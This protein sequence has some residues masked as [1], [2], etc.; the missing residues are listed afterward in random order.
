MLDQQEKL[1]DFDA[2]ERGQVGNETIVEITAENI[3]EYARVAL[4]S[5]PRYQPSAS[6][7]LAMPTMVLSYAPLLRE[8]IAEANGF[9]AYEVSKTARRQTPF[10][11]CEARWFHPVVPGDTITGRRRVLEKYE[12]RGS[13]FVTFRVEAINQRGEKAAEYDYTC[14]FEYAKGQREAPANRDNPR[15]DAEPETPQA[16]R[17]KL[18]DYAAA[19]IGDTLAGLAITESQEIIN[20]RSDFRLAG[21]PNESN[22]HTDEEFAKQNIFGGTVNSG[23]ATMSYVDQMLQFSFPLEAFYGGGSLLMRAIEPFRTTDVVTFG[24]EITEK[25]RHPPDSPISKGGAEGG[26][27]SC[28]VKGLNQR[29]D[30]VCLAD[31]TM[32]M[33]E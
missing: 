21:R 3:A 7:L 27:V 6:G 13:K 8:E 18:L 23:P 4:N 33:P 10:A 12:R 2:V 20:R 22:I 5:D 31:A 29:G 24:G 32:I 19:S 28:Q 11:K 1:W 9:V 15:S 17:A 26:V 16:D 30:L 14:I 25:R